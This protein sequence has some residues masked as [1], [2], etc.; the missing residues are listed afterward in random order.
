MDHIWD[1]AGKLFPT[2]DRVRKRWA[3]KLMRKRD[4]GRVEA[5]FAEMRGFPARK[6]E[7]RDML[8][9]EANYFGRNRERMRYP[10]FREQSPFAGSSVIEADPASPVASKLKD[11]PQSRQIFTAISANVPAQPAPVP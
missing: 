9:T 1:V 11:I 8:G 4:V 5:V 3:W 6:T 2:D 10:K 7:L